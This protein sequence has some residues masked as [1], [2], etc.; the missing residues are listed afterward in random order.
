VGANGRTDAD[1]WTLATVP[2]ESVDH[3]HG[4]FLRLGTDVEVLEPA[5]LRDRIAGTVAA[6]S[7]T[8]D[9][10]RTQDATRAYDV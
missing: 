8:Y 7:R 4:E 2:I 1:G 3:A 9:V 5:E 6:L 10:S